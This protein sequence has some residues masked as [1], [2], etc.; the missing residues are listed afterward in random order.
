M[1]VSKVSVKRIYAPDS[2]EHVIGLKSNSSLRV[3]RY[4][5]G[6]ELTQYEYNTIERNSVIAYIYIKPKENTRIRIIDAG[7]NKTLVEQ[8]IEN[9]RQLELCILQG[10]KIEIAGKFELYIKEYRQL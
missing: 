3:I 5:F 2:Y 8:D 6:E 7:T 10:Q 1:A 9:G 4:K